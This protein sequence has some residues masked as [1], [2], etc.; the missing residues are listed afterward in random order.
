[1]TSICS[2]RIFGAGL[3]AD[4]AAARSS[5]ERVPKEERAA[6]AIPAAPAFAKEMAV[7]RPTPLDAPVMR[8]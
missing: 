6:R 3:F 4:L 8:T 1:M 5:E 7:A 2:S